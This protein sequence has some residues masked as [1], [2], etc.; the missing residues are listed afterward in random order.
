MGHGDLSGGN[1]AIRRIVKYG[2]EILETPCEAIGEITDEVRALVDD[3]VDTCR[4]AE[5]A[6]LAAP[7][8]GVSLR[9][10]VIEVE[11]KLYRMIDPEIVESA[12]ND[13]GPEGCL[14]FPGIWADV[15]RASRVTVRYTDLDGERQELTATG[16]LARACQHEFDHLDGVVF[17]KRMGAATRL[18]LKKKLAKLKI[19][20]LEELD[21]LQA[22]GAL[23]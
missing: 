3:L 14:S 7:Q 17:V 13:K 5:G 9:V 11:G 18:L 15:V 2:E 23:S 6:G 1:V 19:E 22:I 21:A 10:V 4:D 12:G 16:L 8:I 20:T